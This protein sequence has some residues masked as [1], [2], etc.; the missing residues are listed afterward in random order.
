MSIRRTL[1]HTALLLGA[2]FVLIA[3][4]NLYNIDEQPRSFIAAYALAGVLL[5][6]GAVTLLVR[7]RR[8]SRSAPS[9][10]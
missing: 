3:Y 10:H 4:A 9:T 8:R 6:A 2:L 1:A 7:G 5:I